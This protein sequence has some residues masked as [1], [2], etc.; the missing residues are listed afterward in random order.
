METAEDSGD[1]YRG[2]NIGLSDQIRLPRRHDNR[3]WPLHERHKTQNRPSLG[4]FQHNEQNLE[5]KQYKTATKVKLYGT[6]VIPVIMYGSECW[7]LRKENERRILVAGISWLRRILGRSR[8]DRI[9]NEITRRE[10][11]Q[12]ITLID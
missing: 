4:N 9:R 7:C 8:R 5:V 11:G 2:R 1:K 3:G 12:E 10:L 6:I